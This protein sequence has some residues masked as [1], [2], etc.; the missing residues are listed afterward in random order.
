MIFSELMRTMHLSQD[1]AFGV[2]GFAAIVHVH[3]DL[4]VMQGDDDIAVAFC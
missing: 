3:V 2:D 1:A 4:M